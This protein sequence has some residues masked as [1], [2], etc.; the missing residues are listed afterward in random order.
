L[1]LNH[2]QLSPF[3]FSLKEHYIG[4]DKMEK[5]WGDL[6]KGFALGIFEVGDGVK[7][8]TFV[9]YFHAWVFERHWS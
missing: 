5:S 9:K 4:I 7:R 6:R 3:I 8:D 1:F 2:S